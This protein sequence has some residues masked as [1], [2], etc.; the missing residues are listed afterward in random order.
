MAGQRD[1][2]MNRTLADAVSPGMNVPE[3]TNASWA[4]TYGNL[5]KPTFQ[6]MSTIAGAAPTSLAF[7]GEFAQSK[8]HVAGPGT[9]S[10]PS[11][12]PTAMPARR[13][14]T[15]PAGVSGISSDYSP[16]SNPTTPDG[17]DPTHL[18]VNPKVANP[19][20]SIGAGLLGPI[21][22]AAGLANT[23]SGWM[24][25]PTAADAVNFA[26]AHGSNPNNVTGGSGSSAATLGRYGP[27]PIV[28]DAGLTITPSD[29]SASTD[30][31]TVTTAEQAY[32]DALS[33]MPA[34][35]TSTL[36]HVRRLPLIAPSATTA[37]VYNPMQDPA[38]LA[39]LGY[40][41]TY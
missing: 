19:A 38:V 34:A 27:G 41:R 23:V 30:A 25:G 13:S 18:H 28:S 21:G 36:L 17:M 9:S 32:L 22:I 2:T 35:D 31:P 39:A 3:A 29:T 7:G 37:P 15:T 5:N 6:A 24:G 11:A 1:P 16:A 10:D 8:N 33:H 40:G 14:T 26:L 12:S 4:T 20:F